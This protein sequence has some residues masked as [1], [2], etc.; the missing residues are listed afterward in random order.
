MTGY[1]SKILGEHPVKKC[2]DIFKMILE[3]V[4][5]DTVVGDIART[6]FVPIPFTSKKKNQGS[7]DVEICC[8]N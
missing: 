7:E 8:L 4:H 3:G 1:E 2:I 5:G 6:D